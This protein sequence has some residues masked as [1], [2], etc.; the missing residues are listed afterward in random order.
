MQVYLDESGSIEALKR[1]LTFAQSQ[2][3][4]FGIQVFA[5]DA[6]AFTPESI[7]PILRDIRLPVFGGV[8]PAILHRGKLYKRGTIVIG[9]PAPLR[10]SV[11]PNISR[12]SAH[13]MDM[14]V[15]LLGEPTVADLPGAISSPGTVFVWAD[16]FA[17][18]L[19]LL[20][21]AL[22]DQFGLAYHM[23]GGGA[24]SLDFVQRPCIIT[25]RGL[26]ADAAVLAV[27]ALPA[28]VAARHGWRKVSGPYHVTQSSGNVI[29]TLNWR[30]ALQVYRTAIQE[31]AGIE[32]SEEQFY[33]V[34]QSF[35][36][37]IQR[38]GVERMVRDPIRI[39]GKS[40][41]CV[42]DVPEGSL[43]DILTGS[44]ESLI[45]AAGDAFQQA[46][47]A[48]LRHGEAQTAF[49]F[50]CVSRHLF[51]QDHFDQELVALHDSALEMVGVLSLGEFACNG[52][53][54]PAFLNK[55]AVVGMFAR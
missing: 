47:H 51:L 1:L 2:L 42:G 38:Y 53:D 26:L 8:F 10:V 50:D 46:G 54:Y 17:R 41:V 15:A 55:T 4:V 22:Y 11:L 45:A 19:N 21:Q 27:V 5:A 40:L 43:V 7:D 13:E 20:M 32:V 25:N 30:P 6:N 3:D 18:Q 9:V 39:E 14:A 29:H 28:G 31:T 16:G 49:A 48:L 35:P 34:A 44:S 52:R 36:F 12:A 23:L 33:Q 37:G 24:G